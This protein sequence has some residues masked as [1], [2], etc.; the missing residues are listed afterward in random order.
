MVQ[1][2]CGEALNCEGENSCRTPS[3]ILEQGATFNYPFLFNS[4]PLYPIESSS[5][6]SGA[7]IRLQSHHCL[8]VGDV[9]HVFHQPG[10]SCQSNTG[11]CAMVAAT[12]DAYTVVLNAGYTTTVAGG[13]NGYIT[14]ALD[15]T[16][17]RL[18]GAIKTRPLN[19]AVSTIGVVSSG[20]AGEQEILLCGTTDINAGDILDIPSVGVSGA[21]VL[22]VF[23]A[24]STKST[25]VQSRSAGACGCGV[26]GSSSVSLADNCDCVLVKVDQT[27][28]QT[29]IEQPGVKIRGNVLAEM[30]FTFLGDSPLCGF[31]WGRI[32]GLQTKS[33]AVSGYGDPCQDLAYKIGFYT[34]KLVRGF[35]NKVPSHY[36]TAEYDNEIRTVRTGEA[37]IKVAYC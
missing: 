7:S 3:L 27:I 33:I 26:S 15:L 32:N 17:M 37:Y 13:A 21:K 2:S 30:S 9:V 16:G 11:I 14:K 22:A 6:G 18:E 19:Q 10:Q 36:P 29:F 25:Q 31:V 35:G 34:I 24:N 28:T 12:P 1:S 8:Q 20:F 4:G 23:S 5:P